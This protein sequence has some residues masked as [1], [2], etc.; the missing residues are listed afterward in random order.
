AI[1]LLLWRKDGLAPSEIADATIRDRTTITR[2]LDGMEKKGLVAR[3]QDPSDR[4]RLQVLLTE[5]GRGLQAKL[6]PIAG[7]LIEAAH[8][9]LSEEEQR[10]LVMLLS[11]MTQ[12]LLTKE[13]KESNDV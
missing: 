11:K 8:S 3:M 2:F 7:T 4:R 9:G 10:I 12:N 5:K 13:T 1:L 6:V